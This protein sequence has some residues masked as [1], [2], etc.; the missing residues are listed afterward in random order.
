MSTFGRHFE[1]AGTNAMS[2]LLGE[3]CTN[4]QTESTE[5]KSYLEDDDSDSLASALSDYNSTFYGKFNFIFFNILRIVSM[6]KYI[7]KKKFKIIE[8]NK[9]G[10]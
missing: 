8:I 3:K 6:S 9:I 1:P 7:Y 2:D 4:N 10:I 5:T